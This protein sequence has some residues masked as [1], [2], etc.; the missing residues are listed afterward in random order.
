MQVLD[1]TRTLRRRLG[2]I[3]Q[4]DLPARVTNESPC[5]VVQVVAGDNFPTTM[6]NQFRVKA[7]RISGAPSEGTAGT[8][9]AGMSE[10][11]CTVFGTMLPHIGDYLIARLENGGRWVATNRFVAATYATVCVTVTGCANDRVGGG[12]KFPVPG[13][14]VTVS[15][16]GFSDTGTV[17]TTVTG[18]ALKTIGV[19]YT[20]AP[21]VTISGGG[22]SGA[23]ATAAVS[24]GHVTSF[25]V[26]NSGTG[27]T[28]I[29]TVTLTG[30]GASVQAT[31]IATLTSKACISVPSNGTYTTSAS[32]SR[33]ATNTGSVVVTSGTT[34]NGTIALAAD[35]THVCTGLCWRPLAKSL[36]VT[37]PNGTHTLTW[38]SDT[39]WLTGTLTASV[40]VYTGVAPRKCLT[41]A[42]G[43]SDYA[44]DFRV[45][46]TGWRLIEVYSS[47]S[48]ASDVPV[49]GGAP[50]GYY[51]PSGAAESLASE[52]P[53][54]LTGDCPNP[55]S[56]TFTSPGASYTGP[57]APPVAGS[58]I[59]TE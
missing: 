29:P 42:A 26:T 58:I 27:Y 14:S 28:D 24:G 22:G 34:F 36:P 5:L 20:S 12:A 50:A 7:V 32:A 17:V 13:A 39:R 25:T 4:G 35:S 15:K 54:D 41:S 47:Y 52:G 23:T 55:F 45:F 31:G 43:S 2:V 18:I 10:F 11:I 6:P 33:F 46:G 3:E 49:V 1:E 21:T 48:C 57:I 59:V 30:G 38:L 16:V 19:G 56:L 51:A 53:M 8:L 37:D 40:T 44:Y 9:T